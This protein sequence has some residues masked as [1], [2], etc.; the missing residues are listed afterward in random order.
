MLL[1]HPLFGVIALPLLSRL[2]VR[3]VDIA[4]LKERYDWEFQTKHQLALDLLGHVIRTLR[5]LGSKAGFIVVFDGAYAARKLVRSLINEGAVVVT[6]LRRDAKLFDVPESETGKRGR[7]RK[8]GKNRISLIGLAA[9]RDGW[10][11]IRY[12]C[13][14]V[15]AERRY[16][17]FLAT[18]HV[19][20]GMVRV[21]MLEHPDGN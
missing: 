13:R 18:S 20:G 19:V 5:A 4:S 1:S 7:P 9:C 14:G 6:R 21:V 10:Q 12:S 11:T 2:Y 8:Y 17:S 15:M 3:Q 16:H